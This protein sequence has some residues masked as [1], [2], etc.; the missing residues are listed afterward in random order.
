MGNPAPE[1]DALR[2]FFLFPTR[3]LAPERDALRGTFFISR[4]QEAAK[5]PVGHTWPWP[6]AGQGPQ[7][8]LTRRPRS[9][10]APPIRENGIHFLKV[11]K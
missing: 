9:G 7:A 10:R 6:Q 5:R 8:G 3:T 1:R 2:G 4:A 11:S